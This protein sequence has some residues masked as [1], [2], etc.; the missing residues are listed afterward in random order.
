MHLLS[1]GIA[2]SHSPGLLLSRASGNFSCFPKWT[3]GVGHS[4]PKRLHQRPLNPSD[5]KKQHFYVGI[6]YDK[7][8]KSL[9]ISGQL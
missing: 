1:R 9:E 5:L 4:P 3:M 2:R 8:K 6:N 7:V